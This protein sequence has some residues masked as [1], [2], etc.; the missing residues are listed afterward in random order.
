MLMVKGKKVNNTCQLLYIELLLYAYYV[1]NYVLSE[2][3]VTY[4]MFWDLALLLYVIVQWLSWCPISQNV[5]YL[6]PNVVTDF[7]IRI[8]KFMPSV[9]MNY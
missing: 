3:Y 1:G 4:I 7:T 6:T 2:I 9:T 5:A 8:K